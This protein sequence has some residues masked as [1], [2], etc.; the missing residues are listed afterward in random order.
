MWRATDGQPVVLPR[1]AYGRG[2]RLYDVTGKEYIDG[3]G[4][5]AVYCLGHAHPEVNDAIKRQLDAVA[6]A[7]RYNFASDPMDELTELVARRSGPGFSKM[8]FT[9]GGSEAVESALKVALHYHYAAGAPTR[10]RFIARERSWHG[11]TLGALSVSHFKERRA[12]YEGALVPASHLSAVNPY[13]PPLGVAAEDVA[14]ACA[15]E[16]EREIVRLGDENVAGFVFEPV[17]GAAGGAVPAPPGYARMVRDICDRHGVLMI[18]DEVM[19]GTGRCGTWRALEHDGVTP[20]V[21]AVA[22]GLGGGYVPLGATIYH[23][24]V[25]AVLD[26]AGGPLTGHTFTGHT[27]ACAAGLAVQ[28]IVERDRLVERVC[29]DGPRL[30][31]SIE[32]RFADVERVGD[33]RGRGFFVGLELVADPAT[34]QPFPAAV[35]LHLLVRRHA[36]DNGLICYPS[37]GNVD[38]VDG[39]TVIIAPPFNATDDELEEIVDKLDRSVRS[40]LGDVVGGAAR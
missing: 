30:M 4:G 35:G 38:G 12:P 23:D 15:D 17:V 7:Y 24:K 29:A 31:K 16:L 26:G 5:P 28:R 36:L 13:R 2:S 39:D 32:E 8:I 14:A 21:M 19:C 34:K 33:V 20:D 27:L 25:A 11:N 3:S 1:I 9:T 6:H 18:A 37:G 40:A 10:Q 22:K